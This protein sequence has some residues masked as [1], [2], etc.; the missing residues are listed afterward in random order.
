MLSESRRPAAASLSSLS[1]TCRR[2]SKQIRP[3]SSSISSISSSSSSQHLF[4]SSLRGGRRKQR[5]NGVSG[6]VRSQGVRSSNS[7]SESELARE[8]DEYFPSKVLWPG[9]EKTDAY[10]RQIDFRAKKSLGQNFMVQEKVLDKIVSYSDIKAGDRVLEIGS[11]TGNLTRY[12][13]GQG[14]QVVCVEKDDR[15]FKAFCEEFQR[16]IQSE[17]LCVI[18]ADILR[19]LLERERGKRTETEGSQEGE[20]ESSSSAAAA[21]L[22]A[23]KFD[24]IVANLPFNIT[25]DLLKFLLPRCADLFREANDGVPSGDVYLL[26][27][28][29]AAQRLCNCAAGDS[30]YRAMN[31]LIDCY[32]SDREYLF[33]IDRKSFFPAPNVDG[34]LVHFKLLHHE[35]ALRSPDGREEDRLCVTSKQ[36][37]TFVNQ[38][39]SRRRKMLK[40]NIPTNMYDTE[41]VAKAMEV[42]NLDA[43]TRPQDMSCHEYLG[44]LYRLQELKAKASSEEE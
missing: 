3:S 2:S 41:S 35:Q 34:A 12:M 6:V 14:A 18:H 38:C 4:C 11:G 37:Q 7:S 23:M 19:W 43:Q 30:N 20:G 15:L 26:L 24:K 13:L 10:L 9:I 28:D 17:Q 33:K 29:E 36:F 39:F 25:T 8:R 42:M 32:C 5:Q 21:K 16:D 27:Q 22:S 1:L 40:N 31:V 44:L